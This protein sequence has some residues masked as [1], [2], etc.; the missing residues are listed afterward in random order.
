M[1]S[2]TN[3][4]TLSYNGG[5]TNSNT[6][7]GEILETLAATKT[8]VRNSYSAGEDVAYVINLVNSGSTPLGGLTLTDDLGGYTAGGNTVYPLAY[9]ADSVKY[10]INGVLQTAPTATA[11]PPLTIAGISVPAG[12]NATV[13]YEAD[14]TAYAPLAA[15]DTI[16]NTVTV[17]GAAIAT[18]VTA[19]ETIGAESRANLSI[20][21]ALSPAA[22]AERGRITYTFVIE[23][24]GNAA[25]E[26]ADDV[27]FTDN[28]DPILSDLIV[29]YNG[30]AW[31]QGTNYTYDETTGAFASLP[32]QITVPAASYTQNDDGTFTVTPG[33]AT[34]IISGTV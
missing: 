34:L 5:T 10:F 6:V 1:A 29:A 26:I 14:I 21:K 20:S 9:K 33:T 32:G 7:T 4:A 24:T 17:T 23:N 11:G 3:F 12:G 8:A 27:I 22:V 25:A 16:T 13:V 19:T 18:P 15:E 28:F 2:F 31:T 30:T